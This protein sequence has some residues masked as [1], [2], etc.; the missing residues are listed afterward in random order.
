VP[1]ALLAALS[2]PIEQ[3]VFGGDFRW[4]LVG[5]PT[6]G[7][8]SPTTSRNSLVVGIRRRWLRRHPDHL[9]IAEDALS[10]IPPIAALGGARLRG[11]R[12]WQAATRVILPAAVP[13]IFSPR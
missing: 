3:R 1:G 4:F 5:T 8:G 13:G 9:H 12:A 7:W 11:R 6:R 2:W 10:S